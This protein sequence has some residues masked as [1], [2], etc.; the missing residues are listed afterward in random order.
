MPRL[1]LEWTLGDVVRKIRQQRGLTQEQLA[2][3]AQVNRGTVV[4][5]EIGAVEPE[6]ATLK[7]IAKALGV[8]M[9]DIYGW[10]RDLNLLFSL[11]AADGQLVRDL[12]EARLGLAPPEAAAPPSEVPSGGP[13]PPVPLARPR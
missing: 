13:P 3:A 2:K 7:R 5:L 4:E 6:I 10:L 9:A 12:M 1:R 8:S 11:D